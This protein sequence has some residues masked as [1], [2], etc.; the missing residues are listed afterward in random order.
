MTKNNPVIRTTDVWA[1]LLFLMPC[2]VWSQSNRAIEERLDRDDPDNFLNSY[3]LDTN[4]YDLSF[5]LRNILDINEDPIQKPEAVFGSETN[6]TGLN[7]F[8]YNPSVPI[9]QI[10]FNGVPQGPPF[11]KQPLIDWYKINPDGSS[12]QFLP[13]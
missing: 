8:M 12:G 3:N 6:H 2:L 4:F 11:W 5:Y 1:L 7:F 9:P 10:I 13:K